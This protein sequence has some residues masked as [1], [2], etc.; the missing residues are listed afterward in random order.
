MLDGENFWGIYDGLLAPYAQKN[1]LSRGR[2]HQEYTDPNRL[3]FQRDRDRIIHTTSFRRLRGKMQVVS[4]SHSDHFRNR[5]SH[6]IE[7]A[8]FAR[9]LARQLK[10]NEDLA[11]A[12]ALG[13]DLGH[14]PFGH[15]GETALDLKMRELGHHFEHN[16]QSLRIVTHFERRYSDFPGLNLT[17]EVLEGLQKH[18]LNPHLEAQLVDIADEITYLSAD[19]EDGLRGG[20]ID[21]KGLKAVPI[22]AQ[23][24][25]EIETKTGKIHRSTFV[26]RL[27]RNLLAQLIVDTEENIRS[28]EIKTL[29]DVQNTQKTLVMF[30]AAFYKEFLALKKFLMDHYY[31]APVVRAY[32]Q[33]GQE[34]I[35]RGF[36]QLMAN[37][38]LIP[39]EF[40]P[41]EDLALRVCDYIAGM[42]DRFL[43]NFL[44]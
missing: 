39:V 10:L 24:L 29:Q 19:I 32:T 30:N 40:M 1:S 37:P 43:E 31:G 36:D 9:D 38:S 26:R 28:E 12:I 11:E 3:P 42:T 33:A 41:E 5:L 44:D 15:A 4:P 23:A 6:T 27:V 22:C 7:V 14:P 20:F 16:A 2:A 21:F 17:Y 25:S 8:Q 18:H 35:F 13:H 34:K